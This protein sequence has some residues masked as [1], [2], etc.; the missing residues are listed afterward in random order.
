MAM[1][2]AQVLVESILDQAKQEAENILA[3]ARA[4]AT[5]RLA[6]AREELA[7]RKAA[8]E[9]ETARRAAL[10]ERRIATTA[11]LE[12]R[13]ERL[14]AKAALVDEAFAE[15]HRAL[16]TLP[17]EEERAFL[18]R[19]LLAA[20]ETGEEEVIVAPKEREKYAALLAEVNE[21]LGRRGS[22]G[23]LRLAEEVAGPE[24]G[25]VLRGPDYMVDCSFRAL[26]A[27][28]RLVL[29]PEVAKVLFG[30]GQG[31]G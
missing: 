22:R 21:E 29:E 1:G 25:F 17:A 4:K 3:E 27:E 18:R 5:A 2:E 15:A 6:A 11:E 23:G 8:L 28:R 12:I 30:R 10:E 24:G 26:L 14:R 16:A 13:R 31:G 19:L 9:A 20:A 7:Q